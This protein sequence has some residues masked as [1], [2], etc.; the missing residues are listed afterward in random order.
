MTDSDKVIRYP[1]YTDEIAADGIT[2]ID[3]CHQI[4]GGI[5]QRLN[6]R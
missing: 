5:P 3:V 6:T 1:N 2:R 4:L